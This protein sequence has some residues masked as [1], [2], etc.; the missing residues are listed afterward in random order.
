[1]TT[2]D[3]TTS[4]PL[5]AD[6]IQRILFIAPSVH[7]YQ[8][9]PLT[10]NKGYSA[11]QWTAPSNPTA[12]QIFTARLRI[13]ETAIPDPDPDPDPSKNGEETVRTAAVLE[14]PKTGELFAAAPITDE[15]SI[16]AVVDSARFFAVR[17]VGEGGMK[18]VLGL[19]FEDRGEAIDFGIALQEVR[20]VQMLEGRDGEDGKGYV[21]GGGG[22]G[23]M[24]AKG[25]FGVGKIPEEKKDYSLKEGET[26][27]IDIGKGKGRR[28]KA[29]IDETPADGDADGGG[30]GFGNMSFLPPPPSAHDV[31]VE[32]QKERDKMD[33]RKPT[34]G[35][36]DGEFGEFQ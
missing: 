14:D 11:S 6:A 9:P 23:G 20:K 12:R 35:F 7:I 26:I 13:I 5:P 16:Q 32:L 10:S 4:L 27:H 33:S 8:I 21:R 28:R 22:G 25:K 19:G 31:K 29:D 34:S 1:M 3:P 15:A 18:A 2:L 24:G 30:G 17:V 36:D